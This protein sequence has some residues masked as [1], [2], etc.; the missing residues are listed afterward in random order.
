MV[1]FAKA[2][3]TA[4][5]EVKV[6][7]ARLLLLLRLIRRVLLLSVEEA[8]VLSL[9]LRAHRQVTLLWRRIK[10]RCILAEVA[11]KWVLSVQIYVILKLIL[12]V[13]LCGLVHAA[14]CLQKVLLVRSQ[15]L[16]NYLVV[17]EGLES[18]QSS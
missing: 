13:L 9:H 12:H 17:L 8:P 2:T 3:V 15:Y 11:F 1:P 4:R 14:R 18:L 5:I 7:V 10:Q 6:C 16:T